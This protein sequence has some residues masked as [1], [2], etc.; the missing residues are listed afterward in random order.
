MTV[1]SDTSAPERGILTLLNPTLRTLRAAIVTPLYY[2]GFRPGDEVG[3]TAL[4]PGWNASCGLTRP[5]KNRHVVGSEGR[6]LYDV[7]IDVEL[8]PS[9]YAVLLISA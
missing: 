9:S 4:A 2:A 5:V 3:V 7:I 8:R 1:T 6:P